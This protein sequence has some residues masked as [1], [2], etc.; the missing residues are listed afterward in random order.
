MAVSLLTKKEIF[1]FLILMI[2]VLENGNRQIQ[3]GQLL[4]VETSKEITQTS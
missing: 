2:T 4:Q 3:P 1:T